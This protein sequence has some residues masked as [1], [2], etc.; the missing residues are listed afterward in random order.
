MP[1]SEKIKEEVRHRSRN[2]CVICKK[3]FRPCEVHHI[4][5]EAQ[6]NDNTL[7]NA[8]LLCRNHHDEFG[9]KTEF[10]NYIKKEREK[11]YNYCEK[12]MP[13]GDKINE[14]FEKIEKTVGVLEEKQKIPNIDETRDT[15]IKGIDTLISDLQIAKKLLE[16]KDVT[17]TDISTASLY[18]SGQSV[19]A[20]SLG[21]Y[22]LS[23]IDPEVKSSGTYSPYAPKIT[24]CP[25]CGE[26][27]SDNPI[28]CPKCGTLIEDD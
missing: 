1:F 14:R 15:L 17:P 12:Y 26:V 19:D 2:C 28:I 25:N 27:Y 9:H 21:S 3:F 22:G 24:L 10:I 6:S 4:I 13:D 20:D 23:S 7:E 11:W 8:V 16:K 18:L 5:P